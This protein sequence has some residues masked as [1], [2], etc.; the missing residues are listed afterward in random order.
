MNNFPNRQYRIAVLQWYQGDDLA[1]VVTDELSGLGHSPV[2]FSPKE[3]VPKG[4]DLVFTYAP[5]GKFMPIVNYLASL[6]PGTRPLLVH[7]NTEGL[8]DLR[9]PWQITR[10]VAAGRSRLERLI[11]PHGNGR[12]QPLAKISSLSK[13]DFSMQRFRFIGDYYAAYSQGILNVFSDSSAVYA[14]IHN[15]HGLPTVYAPWGSTPRW[16]SDLEMERDIDVL[17]MGKRGTRRRSHLL[18]RVRAELKTH[19]IEIHVA[20]NVENPFIFGDERTEYLNRAKITLNITRTWYDDNF[21]RFSLAAPNRSLVVSEKM[22]P[23]CPSYQVGI[24]YIEAKP[25]DLARAVLYYLKNPAEREQIVE[26]AYRL[27][28]K[29]LTFNNSIKRIMAAVN[30]IFASRPDRFE[31]SF[32]KG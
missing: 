19:G 30:V 25:D 9:I 31:H 4:V 29:E 24:H 15:E 26:N 8:P 21:S 23:H 16:Y 18:D 11:Q 10:A 32:P 7:W 1:N 2:I 12:F 6:P 3:P 27:T 17:W 13:I 5:F 14:G 28:T 22:L 20:D